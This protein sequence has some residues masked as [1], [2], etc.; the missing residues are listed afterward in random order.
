MGPRDAPPT[1]NPSRERLCEWCH[2]SRPKRRQ[3]PTA[4]SPRAADSRPVGASLPRR[5]AGAI[6]AGAIATDDAPHAKRRRSSSSST[7]A[8]ITAV[9]AAV[10]ATITAVTAVDAAATTAHRRP[11]TVDVDLAPSHVTDNAD[12]SNAGNADEKQQQD[13]QRIT[14]ETR[15]TEETQGDL[16]TAG[17]AQTIPTQFPAGGPAAFSHTDA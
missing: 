8:T 1:P 14:E 2:D 5:D 11:G 7:I 12:N 17:I 4:R 10:R 9:A 3:R 16:K 13:Q 15:K 6:A